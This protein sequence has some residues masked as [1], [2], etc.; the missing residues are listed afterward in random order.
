MCTWFSHTQIDKEI[1]D[2]EQTVEGHVEHAN[3]RDCA[4]GHKKDDMKDIT[5][6]TV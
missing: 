1:S 5:V 6:S 2:T 3:E 4:E